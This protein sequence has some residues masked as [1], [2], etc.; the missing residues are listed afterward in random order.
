MTAKR[1]VWVVEDQHGPSAIDGDRPSLVRSFNNEALAARNCARVLKEHVTRY[2]PAPATVDGWPE[3][4][5]WYWVH[6]PVDSSLCLV[7]VHADGF[8][9]QNGDEQ[10]RRD[11][12][13]LRF[14][15]PL[16]IPG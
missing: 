14:W 10:R 16:E 3:R 5:G 9:W 12:A 2:I 6:D 1:E 4:D 11:D 15:G 7:R 13:D 8:T